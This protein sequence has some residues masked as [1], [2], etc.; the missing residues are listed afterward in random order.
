MKI[1]NADNINFKNKK[2][3]RYL[4]HFTKI[5]NLNKIMEDGFIRTSDNDT[6]IKGIFFVELQNLLKRWHYNKSWVNFAT[7]LITKLLSVA[8]GYQKDLAIIKIPTDYL[9]KTKL[10]IRSQNYY[11]KKNPKDN[12]SMIEKQIAQN[13]SH[14]LGKTD[15]IYSKYYKQRKDA[16]EYIYT[17]DIPIYKDGKLIIS[18]FTR[19]YSINI[20]KHSIYELLKNVFK[21]PNQANN[22]S[23]GEL[24]AIENFKKKLT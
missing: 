14:L 1:N 7:S 19:D 8:S 15:A 4:Y 13:D 10:K 11:F 2:V 23:S 12:A 21:N 18:S 22:T 9:N 17:D 3:P 24:K 6:Y 5:E 16:I 20:N